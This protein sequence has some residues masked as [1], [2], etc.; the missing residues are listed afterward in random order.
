MWVCGDSQTSDLVLIVVSVGRNIQH[1]LDLTNNYTHTTAIMVG[2]IM[3]TYTE[4]AG[5]LCL[6]I[7]NGRAVD[8][9]SLCVRKVL[10]TFMVDDGH[11]EDRVNVQTNIHTNYAER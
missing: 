2:R 11:I 5:I 3:W 4:M 1:L 7:E 6:V 8:V 9:V 10:T